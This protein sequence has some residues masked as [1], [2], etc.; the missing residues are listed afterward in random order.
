MSIAAL[1]TGA[2]A[3]IGSWASLTYEPN[4]LITVV[5][6]F[7]SAWAVVC[8]QI[9]GL[10]LGKVIN[11]RTPGIAYLAVALVSP[12]AIPLIAGAF[13]GTSVYL[14]LLAVVVGNTKVKLVAGDRFYQ[15]KYPLASL[16]PLCHLSDE[17][18]SPVFEPII[19]FYWTLG[20]F[21]IRI[22]RISIFDPTAIH[23]HIRT[24][25][26]RLSR[27]GRTWYDTL[28]C[29]RRAVGLL[30]LL[31]SLSRYEEYDLD[32]VALAACARLALADIPDTAKLFLRE[33]LKTLKQD[34][35]E[36][37]LQA[38]DLA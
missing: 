25:G 13:V 38:F 35:R 7:T 22:W 37:I 15:F 33:V 9:E 11:I 36:N 19:A 23:E 12:M 6:G 30:Y 8:Q 24:Y 20:P 5:L 32:G 2:T 17:P 3:L 34:R 27:V 4:L 18:L 16:V 1:I 14:L 29:F 26:K 21:N 28:S 10:I 31:D